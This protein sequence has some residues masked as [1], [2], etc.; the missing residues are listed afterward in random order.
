MKYVWCV[1]GTEQEASV[2]TTLI[3]VLPRVQ[4]HQELIKAAQEHLHN[5]TSVTLCIM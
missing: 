2:M 3:S 4:R 5:K 1:T